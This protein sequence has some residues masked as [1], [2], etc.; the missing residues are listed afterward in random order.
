MTQTQPEA[1]PQP[2]GA[3]GSTALLRERE[4]GLLFA[5]QAVSTLGDR[6][7]MVAMP[8]A[9]LSIP[10][11]G[12]GDVG[13]VLG[14]S[15]L[16]MALFVLV[17]GVWADR[18]PR[19][20]TMLASDIVRGLTQAL[21]AILLL[22]HR[23]T[24][25]ELMALHAVYGAAE[26]FFRPAALGLVPQLVRRDQLQAA[27]GWL[28]LSMN[29]ALV[30]GPALAG[31]LVAVA[32]P[33][34]A[35]AVDAGT[36]AVSAIALA[37]LRPR[38]MESD[39]PRT[40]FLSELTGG[41]REVRSRTW[42]WSLIL[43]FSAY[44]ALVLPA[45]FILGPAVAQSDR[46]GAA[47]WGIISAG[48]GIGAVAGSL[49]ALRWKPSRPGLVV[50]G[51]LCMGATQSVIVVS[52]LPTLGVAA[53]EAVT[54]LGV[55]VCFAVWETALQERIPEQAQSRVSSFDY[56]GSL[57]LMPLGF[58]IIGPLTHALGTTTTAVVATALTLLVAALVAA[59][60]DVRALPAHHPEPARA[61]AG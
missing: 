31:V 4:F 60:R 23:A 37:L 8:F 11:A 5:G 43:T 9:V 54:G 25:P 12:L 3:V 27:N 51:A 56:L 45:L 38:P 48:F 30:G 19:Q 2:V 6:L 21:A 14:A 52:P 50:A 16:T 7:V 17:G 44:H 34:G 47:A 22:T 58:L 40:S 28:S 35:L 26:A 41:W 33:G 32:G 29:V 10:G 18:L 24:V 53:L 61:P 59:G 49:L 39:G 55:A 13:L 46:G 20:Y 42:V 15:A 36:F 1:D 57:T